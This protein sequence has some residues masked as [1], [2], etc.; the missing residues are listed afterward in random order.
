[1]QNFLNILN[2]YILFYFMVSICL[3]VYLS[4]YLSIPIESTCNA[5]NL[6]HSWVKKIPWQPTPIFLPGEFHGQ[7]SLVSYSPCSSM[8]SDTTEQL[9]LS[10]FH[11]KIETEMYKL[12]LGYINT[13]FYLIV[14]CI[15]ID[16]D[17]GF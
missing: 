5:G 3:S 10:L 14:I 16:T 13:F 12:E 15:L 7:R 4:I 8:E 17:G 9:K 2:H 11:I 6:F 1:M